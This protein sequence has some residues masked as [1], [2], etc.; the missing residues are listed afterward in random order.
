ML[1]K[2]KVTNCTFSYTLK[3]V[4]W[5]K[6]KVIYFLDWRCGTPLEKFYDKC[7]SYILR[8]QAQI[9]YL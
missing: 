8:R 2:E 9:I 6:L 5:L 1:R 3:A 7:A 4:K